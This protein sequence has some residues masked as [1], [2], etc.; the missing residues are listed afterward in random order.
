MII[1]GV[2]W[3]PIDGGLS[4]SGVPVIGVVG[5]DTGRP[6]YMTV[7]HP[8]EAPRRSTRQGPGSGRP[9]SSP[10]A[11]SSAAS[12]GSTPGDPDPAVVTG[13]EPGG[14][15]PP[16]ETPPGEDGTT[17]A[18]GGGDVPNAEPGAPNR[19][20]AVIGLIAVTIV[21]LLVIAFLLGLAFV[22]IG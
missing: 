7:S 5:T 3:F 9:S 19:T 15:V 4:V 16:G 12:S 21:A 6:F 10:A 8:G 22:S 17:G 20:P 11:S 2:A 18:V 14:G 13:L 1:C